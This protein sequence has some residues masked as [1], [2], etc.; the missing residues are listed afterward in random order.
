MMKTRI[1]R[2]IAL[3]TVLASA[4]LAGGASLSGF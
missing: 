4:V 1:L 3:L 2:V